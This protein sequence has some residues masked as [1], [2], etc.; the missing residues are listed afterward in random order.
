MLFS[1]FNFLENSSM[2]AYLLINHLINFIAPAAFVALALLL[3]VRLPGR[4]FKSYRAVARNWWAQFAI[5]F[6][7]NVAVLVLGLLLTGRDARML[8]YA[9]LVIGSAV[10]LWVLSRGWKA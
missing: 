5:I 7:V 3:A 9:A 10:T 8:T 6:A 1:S 2:T 4:F